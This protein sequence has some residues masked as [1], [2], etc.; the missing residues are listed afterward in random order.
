MNR[1]KKCKLFVAGNLGIAP[2]HVGSAA[3]AGPELPVAGVKVGVERPG[4]RAIKGV[5]GE[6]T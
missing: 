5:T 3:A 2:P 1:G 6:K 4:E